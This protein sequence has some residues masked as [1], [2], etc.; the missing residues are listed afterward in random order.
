MP[1]AKLG[2]LRRLLLERPGGKD[3]AGTGIS[4]KPTIGSSPHFIRR[5]A[6]ATGVGQGVDCKTGFHDPG[7]THQPS[8]LTQHRVARILA[9]RFFRYAALR[10]SRPDVSEP[11][12]HLYRHAIGPG[13]D[14]QYRWPAG[15]ETAGRERRRAAYL[16]N[17]AARI[18]A[19]RCWVSPDGWWVRPGAGNPVLQSTPWPAPVAC[20][21]R[22]IKCGHDPI[23]GFP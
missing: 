9:A 5:L 23:V 11:A 18:R 21:N 20:A 10:L 17:R 7:R 1:A 15:S 3:F 13:S 16:K 2:A 19:T 12:G 14:T 6:H 4:G 22:R 8:G